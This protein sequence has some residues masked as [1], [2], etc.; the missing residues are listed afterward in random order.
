M[1][2]KEPPP[3]HELLLTREEV[4]S[5]Y[6]RLMK[7]L[8]FGVGLAV[9]AV[10]MLAITRPPLFFEISLILIGL[11]FWSYRYFSKRYAETRDDLI[12]AIDADQQPPP[13]VPEETDA[14]F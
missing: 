2:F 1:G 9:V 5:S 13:A 14:G 10:V 3:D 7:A 6:S 4:E 8:K 12:A 11:E